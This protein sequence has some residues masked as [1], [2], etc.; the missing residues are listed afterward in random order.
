MP[1]MATIATIANPVLPTAVHE[2]ALVAAAELPPPFTVGFPLP[3]PPD[4]PP[5]FEFACATMKSRAAVPL[6]WT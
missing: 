1:S 4:E 5:A 3:S 6:S 2:A